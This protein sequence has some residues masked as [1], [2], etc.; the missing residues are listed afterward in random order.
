M[1]SNKSPNIEANVISVRDFF[2][3][4]SFDIPH[5]QRAYSWT[6]NEVEILIGDLYDAFK[7]NQNS[8]YL[9]GSITTIQEAS[10]GDRF[11]ILDGQQRLTTL[12]QI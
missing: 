7:R 5:Y 6:E 12:S 11:E 9:L 2:N 4:G 10:A 1:N 3:L 8:T